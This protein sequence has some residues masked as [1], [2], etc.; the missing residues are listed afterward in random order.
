MDRGGSHKGYVRTKNDKTGS[1]VR[2][3]SIELEHV[4]NRR[5]GQF[6]A[7]LDSMEDGTNE[8]LVSGCHEEKFVQSNS[9]KL[10]GAKKDLYDHVNKTL[11]APHSLHPVNK[12]CFFSE[13]NLIL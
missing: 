4:T 5:D 10:T 8:S 13:P 9:T 6:N 1:E 11:D 3:R 12:Y 7:A 2:K